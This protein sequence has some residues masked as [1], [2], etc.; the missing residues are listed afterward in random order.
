MNRNV[1]ITAIVTVLIIIAVAVGFQ[2]AYELRHIDSVCASKCAEVFP[3]GSSRMIEGRC[4]CFN[5]DGKL[6]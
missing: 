5:N 6:M 1:V 3:A 2:G 4:V